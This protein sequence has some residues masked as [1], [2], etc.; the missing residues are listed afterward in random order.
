MKGDVFW[1]H[2][3]Q[4]VKVGRGHRL[5]WDLPERDQLSDRRGGHWVGEGQ[6]TGGAWSWPAGSR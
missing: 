4:I 1:S 3:A 6:H 5:G 2:G